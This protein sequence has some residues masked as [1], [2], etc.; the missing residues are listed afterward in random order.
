MDVDATARPRRRCR[1]A[2]RRAHDVRVGHD[3]RPTPWR[4][5]MA[6]AAAPVSVVTASA[7]PAS[8]ATGAVVDALVDQM[9]VVEIVRRVHDGDPSSGE[10]VRPIVQRVARTLLEAEC[11][12]TTSTRSWRR[13]STSHIDR[14]RAVLPPWP[15]W[16][17]SNDGRDRARP[18][19]HLTPT[20]T[21][22]LEA[23][24]VAVHHNSSTRS[25][26]R[27]RSGSGAGRAALPRRWRRRGPSRRPSAP[28]G[29]SVV[30]QFADGAAV[31]TPPPACR[32]ARARRS[33]DRRARP[34]RVSRRRRRSVPRSPPLGHLRGD[35]R[36]DESAEARP[37][38]G[39]RSTP[40]RAS[41][42]SAR[43]APPRPGRVDGEVRRLSGTSRPDH[44]A[45][46]HPAPA[47]HRSRSTPLWITSSAPTERQARRWHGTPTQR[48]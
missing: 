45:A 25:A 14:D 7:R 37:H 23:R 17:R 43:S 11:R 12:S 18:S 32:A 16:R 10:L 13:P 31:E 46:G 5:R 9:R 39:R 6:S 8:K 15:T 19:C 33:R 40:D 24:L 2:S 3:A 30:D 47:P 28:A 44:D 38:H 20:V 42:P 4:R 27:P 48:R 1:R 34:T 41:A 21:A 29:R 35:R 22:L 26:S 36:T